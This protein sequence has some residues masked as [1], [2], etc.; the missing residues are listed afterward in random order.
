VGELSATCVLM[1]I[2]FNTHVAESSPTSTY[3][4]NY[5]KYRNQNMEW[6]VRRICNVYSN[7]VNINVKN[8]MYLCEIFLIMYK[9]SP[10]LTFR[11]A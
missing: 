8:E 2:H 6:N 9:N 10:L 7:I 3:K 4:V 1:F 5:F 11:G